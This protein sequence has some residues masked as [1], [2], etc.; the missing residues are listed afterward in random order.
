MSS[1]ESSPEN[2]NLSDNNSIESNASSNTDAENSEQKLSTDENTDPVSNDITPESSGDDSTPKSESQVTDNTDQPKQESETEK[3]AAPPE[4]DKEET[5]N[6]LTAVGETH[7]DAEDESA[8]EDLSTLTNEQIVELAEKYADDD[9][10]L[11]LRAIF[12]QLRNHLKSIFEHEREEHLRLFL[13]SGGIREEYEK[14]SNPLVDRFYQAVKKFSKRKDEFLKNREK[15]YQQNLAKK[16]DILDELRVV[17]EQEENIG[18]AF[19]KFRGLQDRWR[20]VGPVP[21]GEVQNLQLSYRF[22]ND[23]FYQHI[24]INRELQ[25]LDQKKNLEVKTRLC[26]EAEALFGEKSFNNAFAQLDV[27]QQHWREVG[28]VPREVKD[29]IWERFLAA[30]NALIEKRKEYIADREQKKEGNLELKSKFC[31]QVEAITPKENWKHKDWQSATEQLLEIQKE[32][33]KVGPAPKKVN[34]EIWKRFRAAIDKIFKVKNEFY[35][36]RKKEYAENLKLKVDLCEKAENLM[37][38]TEWKFTTG[39]LINLQKSW[40]EIGPAG[41]RHS[42]KVWKRFRA[43]CDTF[44][45]NKTEHFSE[46]DKANE[47]NLAKKLELL[48]KIE[49]YE[50]PENSNE[51]VAA[52]RD[53]QNQWADIGYVPIKKKEEVQSRFRKVLDMHYDKLKLDQN[54]KQKIRYQQKLESI[55]TSDNPKKL[56][57]EKRFLQNKIT[58]LK[59]NVQTLENNIGFFGNSKG[60]DKMKADFEKKI[61]KSKEEISM[62]KEKLKLLNS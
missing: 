27:L 24:N 56:S 6:D 19:E 35:N 8:A 46:M 39:E 49:K 17:A 14:P 48:E 59:N 50:Q 41:E 25:D 15:E 54:E 23:L 45:N 58:E 60:A 55:R 61:R 4:V 28:M 12:N 20:E 36:S 31:E 1:S 52:L 10:L 33:R 18:L 38:S 53:F 26:E 57:N 42:N 37:N 34:D 44:F 2:P 51:A 9:H 7:D 30:R 3:V 32:W 62:L 16:Q 13:E 43:A 5:D 40:K 29:S 47:E 21:F 22:L 11:D